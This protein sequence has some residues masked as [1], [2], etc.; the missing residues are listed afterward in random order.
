MRLN[1]RDYIRPNDGLDFSTDSQFSAHQRL[2]LNV[3]KDMFFLNFLNKV[4]EFYY[5]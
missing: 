1:I 4:I 3:M 2:P 5:R